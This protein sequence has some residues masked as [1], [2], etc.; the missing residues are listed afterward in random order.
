MIKKHILSIDVGYGNTKAVWGDGKQDEICFESVAPMSTIDQNFLSGSGTESLDR[1][2]ISVGGTSY[3]VG[4]D[5]LSAGGSHAL[6][7]NYVEQP[8]YL[9]LLRGAIY[10]MFQKT[11]TVHR[12][13][14]GLVL[15]LPVSNYSNHKAMLINLGKQEHLIPVP[16]ALRQIYG[17]TTSVTADKVMV[18]PQ[19]M[20]ALRAFSQISG[21][22]R[23]I[24]KADA[25][26]LVI[27]PGYNTFDWLTSKGFKPD[28]ERSGSF[29]GG[30]SQMLRAVSSAAGTGLGVGYVDPVECEKALST[31]EL[32]ANGRKIPFGQYTE[33]AQNAARQA[34]NTFLNAQDM[35]RR[36]DN[37]IMTGGGAK[38]YVDELRRRLPGY[39]IRIEQDSI[40][41]NARGFYQLSQ[42]MLG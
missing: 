34:V 32:R 39:D 7:P 33:V 36:F 13:L 25:V 31:G 21:N 3:L 2:H 28:L 18:L 23:T 10:Y 38:F 29:Q 42:D 22:D 8:E 37:I 30:V 1:V 41:M 14:D 16:R 17:D 4:P 6:N 5:A 15:G 40:M 11:G 12:K 26:N 9:A 20:G 24:R 27:D 35:T 19:P